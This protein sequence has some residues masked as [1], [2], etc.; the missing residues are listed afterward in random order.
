MK[1]KSQSYRAPGRLRAP[2][3]VLE[4]ES[5]M[6]SPMTKKARYAAGLRE[7][8]ELQLVVEKREEAEREFEREVSFHVMQARRCGV[9]EAVIAEVLKMSQQA[10]SKRYGTGGQAIERIPATKWN[11][12]AV[13]LRL[14][15]LRQPLDW[16]SWSYGDEFDED[17]DG[18]RFRG[19]VRQSDAAQI[20][21]ALSGNE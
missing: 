10:V 7:L 4:S 5:E 9:G 13:R 2:Q 6:A 20:V 14:P 11:R 3:G 17:V 8:E 21:I 16:Q 19:T 15:R 12:E 18:E 1:R